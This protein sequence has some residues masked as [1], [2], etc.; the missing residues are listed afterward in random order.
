MRRFLATLLATLLAG[1]PVGAGSAPTLGTIHGLVTV[2]GRPLTGAEIAL[3]DLKSGT[4]RRA[5]SASGG[6]F[7][8]QL[9]PGDYV[10]TTESRSGLAISQAPSVVPVRPGET[11]SA[12]ID[13]AA[14]PGP[15]GDTPIVSEGLSITH[16]P[17]GCLLEGEFPLLDANIEPAAS[18]AEARLYFK[19]A[20]SSGF[21]FVK[22]TAGSGN[23]V[24]KLPRPKIEASPILYYVAA[25][26]AGSAEV[27]TR[28]HS[29][30]VVKS[31]QSC[32]EALAA[33]GPGGAV[34]VYSAATGAAITPAGFAASG[35]A[36]TAGTL[37]LL[38]GSAAAAGISATVNV[39]NPEP[40][41]S[42]TPT[43]RPTPTPTPTPIPSPTPTPTPSPTSPPCVTPPC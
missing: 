29:A 26:T 22:M 13:L 18:V 12:R 32:K 9:P 40:T 21:Y 33:I 14:V 7:A 24:G 3:V 19:S 41:P 38:V 43:A 25:S 35:L 10:V 27:K 20:L 15:A 28:E 5:T 34:Q 30:I 11:V 23:F 31:K 17:V 1:P 39:F 42:P 4:I 16:S 8:L 6:R 36:L 37:A 2:D